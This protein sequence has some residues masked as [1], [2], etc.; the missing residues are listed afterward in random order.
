MFT[1]F[2]KAGKKPSVQ[3]KSHLLQSHSCNAEITK[4]LYLS[5][6]CRNLGLLLNCAHSLTL[7]FLS[8]ASLRFRFLCGVI[9]MSIMMLT[10]QK[11]YC[12]FL[13][14]KIIG[15]IL[16]NIFKALHHFLKQTL[17]LYEIEG[18]KLLMN[19]FS[20]NFFCFFAAIW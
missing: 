15:F 3:Q 19:L 16:F 2:S 4:L 8:G 13:C 14:L 7:F 20:C 18:L 9:V 6:K 12:P 10:I 11:K 17:V 5:G 1:Y